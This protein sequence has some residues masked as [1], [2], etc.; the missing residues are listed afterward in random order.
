MS[1]V[2]SPT[3]STEKVGYNLNFVEKRTE[4]FI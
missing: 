3:F 4:D 1:K 2:F